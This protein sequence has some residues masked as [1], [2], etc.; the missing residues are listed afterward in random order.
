M[1]RRASVTAGEFDVRLRTAEDF[2]YI[3]RLLRVFPLNH[4][5]VQG[6]VKHEESSEDHLAGG[7]HAAEFREN[8]YG[9]FAH[10]LETVAT[11]E[12]ERNLLLGFKAFDVGI[13]A[14]EG[15]DRP[16]ALR[17][18]DLACSSIGKFRRG[19]ILRFVLRGV[20]SPRLTLGLYQ[21]IIHAERRWRYPRVSGLSGRK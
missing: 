21:S 10:V 2:A 11:G 16:M 6:C 3:A 1:T 8:L 14:L 15:G 13:A 5:S 19:E 7:S 20:R 17:Y 4:V 12:R 18:F 9:Q